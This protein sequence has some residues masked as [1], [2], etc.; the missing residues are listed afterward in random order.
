VLSD[1]VDMMGWSKR[2]RKKLKQAA[3]AITTK[4]QR[5]NRN[6]Q[7]TNPHSAA[8]WP[9]QKHVK[10]RYSILNKVIISGGILER[11]STK[12]AEWSKE[13][14]NESVMRFKSFT[15]QSTH[16]SLSESPDSPAI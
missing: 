14:A 15:R 16:P 7:S 4:R 5:L 11:Y 13:R 2:Q 12:M 8:S 9:G 3:R 10:E 1:L 6:L